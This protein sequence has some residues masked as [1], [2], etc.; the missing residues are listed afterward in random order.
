MKENIQE[1]YKNKGFFLLLH[2]SSESCMKYFSRSKAERFYQLV[3]LTCA[4]SLLAQFSQLVYSFSYL[5][6]RVIPTRV[7]FLT[8]INYTENCPGL[9]ETSN[10]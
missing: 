6:F 9:L 8:C 2:M 4:D 7:K 5:E 1:L 3:I 10:N